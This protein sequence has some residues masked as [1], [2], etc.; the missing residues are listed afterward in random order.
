LRKVVFQGKADDDY[1]SWCKSSPKVCNKIKKL[2]GS[3]LENPTEGLGKPEQLK[4]DYKDYWSRRINQQHRLVYTFNDNEILIVQ[5]KYH[6][7]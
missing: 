1:K 4:R 7:L 6:Y 2:I 5:C 3:I